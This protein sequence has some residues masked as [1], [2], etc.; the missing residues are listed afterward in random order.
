MKLTSIAALLFLAVFAVSCGS[1]RKFQASSAEDK[2]LFAAINELN[3]RP[4]NEKAQAD[5]KTYFS[6]A[7]Q[8]H[9]DMIDAYRNSGDPAK[10]SKILAELNALQN[11]YTSL[12]ATPGT[13]SLVRPTNYQ[14]Q[15]EQ[16]REQAAADFYERG[17]ALLARNG[18]ENALQAYQEFKQADHFIK[19]Y[20]DAERLIQESYER[21]VVNVVI[22]PIQDNNIMFSRFDSWGNDFRYR[23]EEYQ[24]AL[25][26]DLGSRRNDDFPARF[27]TDREADRKRIRPDYEINLSW[28]NL[29]GMRS[30]PGRYTRQVSKNIQVGSDTAGRPIYRQVF[31]T[32]QITRNIFNVRGDLEYQVSDG[33]GRSNIDYGMVSDQ[34]QWEDSYATYSGDSRALSTEDWSLVNNTAGRQSPTRSDIMNELMRKIYPDLRRRIESAIN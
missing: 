26:R 8:H 14:R 1:S 17:S 29:D 28:R 27:L 15:I 25:A 6:N 22:N 7:V 18:R 4:A 16:V 31:A 21:S 5:L 12:Q 13:F 32:L 11:I 19:G 24:Q 20:R 10:W 9:E 3:K 23:P 33:S 2:P 30:N 34:V